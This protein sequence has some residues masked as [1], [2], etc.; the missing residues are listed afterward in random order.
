[1]DH[2]AAAARALAGEPDRVAALDHL[3]VAWRANHRWPELAELVEA[4]SAEITRALTPIDAELGDPDYHAAWIAR[5]AGATAH[6]LEI[7]IPG[8]FRGPLGKR[9]RERFDLLAPFADDPRMCAA[10]G[11][12][13]AEPPVTAAANFSLWAQ[14]FA[15]LKQAPDVRLRPILDQR[16]RSVGGASQ[17]WPMLH[18]RA[19]K[20]LRQLPNELPEPSAEQREQ[21]AK[22]RERIAELAAA[23]PAALVRGDTPSLES[24]LLAKVYANPDALEHRLVC[25]DALLS[26]GD[27]R[28]EFIQLQLARQEHGG[29]PSKRERQLLAAH[30]LSWLGDLGGVIERKSV[31]FEGGFP[32][33]GEVLFES[34]TQR[35]VI[36]NEA[37]AT[38]REVDTD[39]VS[40]LTDPCMRGLRRAG[41]FGF[42]Q[43][44]ELLE[45]LGPASGIERLGPVL[46]DQLP[47]FELEHLM[48]AEASW[49]SG[50]RE[51]WLHLD[52]HD[53]SKEPDAFGWLFSTPLGR[54]LRAFRLSSFPFPSYDLREPPWPA[55]LDTFDGGDGWSRLERLSLDMS[56]LTLEFVREPQ[57]RLLRVSTV[58][59]GGPAHYHLRDAERVL[60][61]LR[62]RFDALEIVSRG[63]K[64][65]VTTAALIFAEAAGFARFGH[66]HAPGAK[67][68]LGYEGWRRWRKLIE[69][70]GRAAKR[71]SKSRKRARKGTPKPRRAP[72]TTSDGPWFRFADGVEKLGLG[73]SVSWLEFCGDELHVLGRTLGGLSADSLAPRWALEDRR[74]ASVSCVAH[75]RG[76]GRL[77]LGT[78][79]GA[80]LLWDLAGRRELGRARFHRTEVRAVAVVPGRDLLLSVDRD[81]KLHE[82][83]YEPGPG[84]E[85]VVMIPRASTTLAAP[86]TAM[87]VHPSGDSLA[88]LAGSGRVSLRSV[89]DLSTDRVIGHVGPRAEVLRWAPGGDHLIAGRRDGSVV[90]WD[91]DG[92]ELTEV[93]LHEA[94]V[95]ALC[96]T[97]DGGALISAGKRVRVTNRGSG[98]ELLVIEP[99]NGTIGSLAVSEDGAVLA[100]GAWRGVSCWSL[101]DGRL[102]GRY[103]GV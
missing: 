13:I 48:K 87:A 97:P 7:L 67:T 100:V 78:Y 53:L 11:R 62:G 1:M 81:R 25:A 27:P 63:A 50:V 36:G 65:M 33:Y 44:R 54:R 86:V 60:A 66:V 102:L 4:L 55:W 43:L 9:I 103:P 32:V 76:R 101:R 94:H 80:T 79:K 2:L 77:W 42:A 49:L 35:A 40:L 16:L 71:L 99:G 23:P 47:P 24:E 19:L 41:G 91:A 83:A 98:E 46:V 92:T 89:D 58:I 69:R 29:R 5:A 88:L 30:E 85:P 70:Q 14:L 37:W 64:P 31:R 56:F 45:H 12:M 20:L 57:R 38:F 17:F 74:H 68:E 21:I 18:Q 34:A 90:V 93:E 96:S 52:Q 75:D 8:L 84:D 95:S 28:G 26:Q 72:A 59:S 6:E 61:P 10:F 3:V 73:G 39:N 22:L 51:L 82:W 15:R